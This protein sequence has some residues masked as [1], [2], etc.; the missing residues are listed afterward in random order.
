M[1][2]FKLLKIGTALSLACIG[3]TAQAA[4]PTCNYNTGV[5]TLDVGK[6]TAIFT[7]HGPYVGGYF[8]V[9]SADYP[10]ASASIDYSLGGFPN[11]MSL[12]GGAGKA[13]FSYDPGAW[14][15]SG[16]SGYVGGYKGAFD[17]A[18]DDVSFVAKAG[19]ALDSI[20]FKITGSSS[21]NGNGSVK[22][23]VP[24]SANYIGN[25]F[26]AEQTFSLATKKFGASGE[27]YSIYDENPL[28]YGTA[29]LSFDSVSIWANVHSIRGTPPVP[30]PSTWLLSGI[31]L[32]A[33]GA[34]ARKRKIS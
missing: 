33:V 4:T 25:N 1:T 12:V 14:A 26:S 22:L 29:D 8:A 7:A 24:G 3:L 17:F 34:A 18:F 13:G 5:C 31:G 16:G 27:V 6:A 15:T 32:L 28:K 2:H 10:G 19:Y 20:T 11:T 23:D 21:T 9:A 30:E